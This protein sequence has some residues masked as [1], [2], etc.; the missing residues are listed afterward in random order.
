MDPIT[1]GVV[2]L[3]GAAATIAGAT[4]DI[5][6]DIGSESNPNSQVQ[7]APQMGHLHRFINKATSGEPVAYGV[8]AGVAGSVAYL[9]LHLFNLNPVIAIA[10]GASVAALVHTVYTVTSHLGRIVGQSQFG[11]PVYWDALTQALGP[12]AGH[13]FIANFSIVAVAY[14][15]TLPIEG[16]AHPF[17]LPLLAVMWGITLGAIGSSTGDVHYGTESEFQQY[18][19]GGGIPVANHGDINIKSSVGVKNSIDVGNFCAK[20]GGPLTG[21]CFGLLVFISFWITVIFGL[22]GGLVAGIII[23]LILIILNNRVEVFARKTYGP[24]KE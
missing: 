4:E 24:Y 21:I 11:Q 2:A 15:I 3:M 13:G 7:L 18:P 1:L 6:T 12:I 23:V 22:Y 8:W 5:E 19:F 17:P 10:A 14:L 20:F 9:F 16:L